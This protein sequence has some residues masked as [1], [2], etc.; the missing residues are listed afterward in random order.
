MA[1]HPKTHI[2]QINEDQTQR[3]SIKSSKGK[4][5][6]Q[7][8]NKETQ[9]LNDTI[10][11]LDLI[12]IYRAFHPKLMNFTFFSSS[13]ETFSRIENILGHKSSLGKRKKM[14]IISS[15][16]SDHNA[17]RLVLITGEKL[18]KIPTYGS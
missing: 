8:I 3:T 6:K 5:T 1:K 11:Q 14:E 12:D 15:I 4:T 10:G 16:F 7:K 13:R 18:L 9:T 2:N 17:V